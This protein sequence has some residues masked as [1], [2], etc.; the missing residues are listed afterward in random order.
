MLHVV[1]SEDLEVGLA[2]SYEALDVVMSTFKM[3]GL[4]HE[5]GFY[6]TH[7]GRLFDGVCT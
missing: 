7:G 4:L 3:L 6:V 5:Y 1:A 2:V